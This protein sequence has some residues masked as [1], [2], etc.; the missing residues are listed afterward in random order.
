L[1][2]FFIDFKISLPL[3]HFNFLGHIQHLSD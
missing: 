1:Y 3:L 2:T